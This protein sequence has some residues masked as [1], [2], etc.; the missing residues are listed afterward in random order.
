MG[1]NETPSGERLHI[2]LFGRRNAG[3]SSLMN[4]L[5]GQAASVVSDVAGTTTDPVRKAMELLPIGPVVFI[6][7]PGFDDEGNL[8]GLRVERT[9]QML[10]TVDVALLLIDAAAGKSETDDALETLFAARDI[11]YLTVYTKQDLALE[12]EMGEGLRVSAKTGHNIPKLK[13]QIVKTAANRREPPPLLGDLVRPGDFVVLVTPIDDAAPKGRLILPQQ[14]AIR[15]LLDRGAVA[16]VTK[17]TELS[18][19][20][21]TLGRNPALVVTDSQAFEQ[22]A[23]ETPEDVRLTSFSILMARRKGLLEAAVR[24]VAAIE[25]LREGDTVLVCEGCTHHRQCGDIGSVKLPRWLARHTGKNLNI[26]LCSGADFPEDLSDTALVLH[27]GGCLL[28]ERAMAH[29]VRAARTQNVPITNYGT[30]IA[31]MK[32]ILPRSLEIFPALR[33]VLSGADS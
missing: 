23:A 31:Y 4:A 27:C 25:T 17:E 21:K 11:P 33:A 24:G 15:D 18:H 32:G 13:E 5:T 29:R 14:Q 26:R 28:N 9:R 22:V 6:D 16:V 10:E 20:L 1:M 19:T 12:S 8:G 2:G 3:K 7:T 30:A